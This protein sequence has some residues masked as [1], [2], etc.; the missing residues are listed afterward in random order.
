MTLAIVR[1]RIVNGSSPF[2]RRAGVDLEKPGSKKK[3]RGQ[4]KRTK[5]KEVPSVAPGKGS[6][7]FLETKKGIFLNV[8]C[9]EN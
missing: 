9:K 3:I 8:I 2:E 6:L 1:A 5:H 4:I 7:L